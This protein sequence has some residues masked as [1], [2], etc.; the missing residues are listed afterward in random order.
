MAATKPNPNQ[1]LY[2]K[3]HEGNTKEK[4]KATTEE[5]DCLVVGHFA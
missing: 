4:S 5:T 3:G 1:N 2:H